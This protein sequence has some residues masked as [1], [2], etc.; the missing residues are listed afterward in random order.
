LEGTRIRENAAGIT[1]EIKKDDFVTRK[2]LVD[3]MWMTESQ[4]QEANRDLADAALRLAQ[5][6]GIDYETAYARLSGGRR[7]SDRLLTASS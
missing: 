7:P 1:A 5:D 6:E 3:K 4:Y 2:R